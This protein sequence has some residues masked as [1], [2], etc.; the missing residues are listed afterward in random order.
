MSFVIISLALFILAIIEDKTLFKLSFLIIAL[1]NIS[2]FAYGYDWINYYDTYVNIQSGNVD[3]FFTEPGYL[4]LMIFSNY[5]G[6]NFSLFSASVTFLIY[7]FV[8]LFCRKMSNPSLAFFTLF[9]FLG[10]FMFIE[11]IRQGLALCILLLGIYQLHQGNTRKFVIIVLL[12]SLFHISAIMAFLF[13]FMRGKSERGMFKF[14][15]AA[16]IFVIA[17]LYSLYHPDLFSSLPLIGPKV[18]AYARLSEEKD[19]GFWEYVLSSRLV[20]IYLFL[21]LFLF[22]Q[23]RKER[24]I[25]S[26]LGAVLVLFLSRLSPYL[27]RVGYY[28]VPYLV[29]SV[30][31]YMRKQGRGFHTKFNKLVYIMIIFM[32]STIPAWNPV[33]WQGAKTFLTIA[34]DSSDINKEISRKCTILKENYDHIVIVQCR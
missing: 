15:L 27:V 29:I 24:S 19:V 16:T 7:L 4:G 23:R 6:L 30:D 20:F 34:S 26:G 21:Y 32:V 2:T 18:A 17:L 28:F 3:T 12:A 22:I 25:Y 9:S 1:Y 5:I 10:F 33:Y 31:E 8:Y 14:A 11:Q 13:L